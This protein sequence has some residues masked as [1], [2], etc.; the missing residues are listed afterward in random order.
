MNTAANPDQPSQ[1]N[2][3]PAHPEDEF[4]SRSRF[5]SRQFL[6]KQWKDWRWFILFVFFVLIPVKSSLADWN[7]VPTGS[8]NPTIIEGDMVFVNK[9]AY[10]LRFPL[11]MLRITRWAEPE[12]GDIV[13]VFSPED[14]KRLVKRVAGRPGDEIEM[15]DNVLF[16]NG[17]PLQ[18]QPKTQA[19]GK[20]LSP[21]F[22]REAEFAEEEMSGVTHWVMYLPRLGLARSDFAK[23]RVPPGKLFVIGDS[24]DNSY[25]SRNFGAVDREM[26]VGR[27]GS[28]IVSFDKPNG[29]QP[30]WHRFFTSLYR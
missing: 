5:C 14:G 15:K 9:A 6:V 7:W 21:V 17:Q 18:Y 28:V 11:T 30:R 29:W 2:P 23:T 19:I 3:E 25:D 4:G 20:D 26:V 22:R 8:M 27:A 12:I 10:D 24:R 16:I 13:V 1:S